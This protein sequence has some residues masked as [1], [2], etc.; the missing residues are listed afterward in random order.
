MLEMGLRVMLG[1]V[2]I[3]EVDGYNKFPGTASSTS[4]TNL[5]SKG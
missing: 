2:E 4:M 1:S 3:Q 5:N